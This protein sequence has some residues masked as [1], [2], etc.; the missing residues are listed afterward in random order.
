ML[1]S[2]A[3]TGRFPLSIAHFQHGLDPVEEGD[4]LFVKDLA[5]RLGLPFVLGRG[6]VQERRRREGLSLEEAARAERFR[7]LENLRC[8]LGAEW[9]VLGHTADDQV[10]TI[11]LRLLRGAGTSGL[12]G[13]PLWDQERRVLHPLLGHWRWETVEYCHRRGLEPRQ[14]PS[15]SDLTIP[16]NFLRKRVLPL[17]EEQFP[18]CKQA[19]ARSSSILAGED[20]YMSGQS[21]LIVRDYC[22]QEG[23]K[24]CLADRTRWLPTALTRR[25]ILDALHQCKRK[26]SFQ[27]VEAVRRLLIGEAGRQANLG[28]GW[29]ALRSDDGIIMTRE[30]P[31]SPPPNDFLTTLQVPGRT[32]LPD[33]RA[34]LAGW[35]PPREVCL[36]GPGSILRPEAS[37][38]SLRFWRPGDRFQPLGFPHRRKLQ[39]FFTDHKVPAPERRRVPLL[40]CD[41]DVACLV[42][43]AVSER[44]KLEEHHS[45]ALH[46]RI[47]TE[48][49]DDA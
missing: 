31:T 26:T 20:L 15:N 29:M 22:W 43:M 25:L 6:E 17:L 33:G 38:G 27:E 34:V 7:F 2:L 1:L 44:W 49:K 23:E 18:G 19:M 41:Q 42:G 9:I 4:C 30:R 24:M 47:E 21:R 16:R 10:E 45:Q 37:R 8:S 13:I 28:G 11:L 12:K 48:E 46:L 14:D 5:E 35:I 40:I 3:E 39:D 36:G 32:V